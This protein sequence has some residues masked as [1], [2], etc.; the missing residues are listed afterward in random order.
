MDAVD[1]VAAGDAFVGALSARYAG[2]GRLE[3]ALRFA[4]AAGALA[5]TKPG[6]QPS[7]PSLAEVEALVGRIDR[8]G[9]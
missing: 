4:S 7:L 3:D 1:C 2:P 9:S 8:A 6:A 5:C